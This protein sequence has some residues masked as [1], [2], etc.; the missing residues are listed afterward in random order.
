MLPAGTI[1]SGEGDRLINAIAQ[2]I[3]A[4]EMRKIR[5]LLQGEFWGKSF[6]FGKL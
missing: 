6:A 1:K 5:V 3:Q 4:G 2:K